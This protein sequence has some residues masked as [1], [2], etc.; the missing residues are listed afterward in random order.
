MTSEVTIDD[1]RAA[2]ARLAGKVRR[3][4]VIHAEPGLRPLPAPTLL[5]LESLQV[6]GSFK[7][8]GALNKA[9]SLSDEEATHGLVTASAGN[10]GL[11]VAYAGRLRGCPARIYLPTRTPALK[12]E[13]LQAWGAEVVLEGAV[14][15]DANAAAQAAAEREGLNYIHPFADPAVVAGQGTLA[16]EALEDAPPFDTVLCAIGGGGL[17]GGVGVAIHATH[18][19]V[20]VIGIEPEGAAK[21]HAS[22]EA[23]DVVTLEKIS[24]GAG[25][26]APRRSTALNLALVREHVA[27]VVLV[28]DPQMR[29]AARWL[30]LEHAIASELAGAAA[31]AA[32][33]AG[34]YVPEP[35]ERVLALVCGSGTAGI[36]PESEPLGS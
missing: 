22:L 19:H 15:D 34:R 18:P 36:D 25:S 29:E 1:V 13:K 24:T 3:T 2:S 27:R 23:G 35:G 6:T 14:W 11:G 20:K 12:I 5:K 9:L 7:A 16:L 31:V 28:S 4:P 21:M 8:R 32:L 30:W 26:L 17:I 33:L 10:H